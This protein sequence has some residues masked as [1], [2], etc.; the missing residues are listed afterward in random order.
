MT[1]IQ[2]D[3][4][5]YKVGANESLWSEQQ[6]QL[7][8]GDFHLLV[9]RDQS[10]GAYTLLR[11]AN[12]TPIIPTHVHHMDDE[13]IYMLDG[14]CTVTVGDREYV[15]G[16]GDFV[17][18]PK[19]VPHSVMAHG[20]CTQLNIVAPGGYMD[21]FM[22]EMSEMLVAGTLNPESIVELNLK[23]GVERPQKEDWFLQK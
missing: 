11:V 6:M 22:E 3:S 18:M 12:A 16:P 17:F 7:P 9:G 15:L 1:F 13:S 8:G 5:D 2:S 21:K 4:R 14:E 10:N 23:Y 19:E 20:P